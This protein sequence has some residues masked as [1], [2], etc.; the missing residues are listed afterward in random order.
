MD[1]IGIVSGSFDPITNGHVHLIS[2]ALDTL[3][4]DGTLYIVIAYNVAKKGYFSLGRRVEQITKV[5]KD[6]LPD[7]QFNQ[8]KVVTVANQYTATY[9]KKIGATV[10]YRGIRNAAD[11]AYETDIQQ[12]NHKINPDL[13]TVFFV[14]LPE[15]GHISSSVVRG[16]VGFE[17]WESVITEYVHPFII[18]NFKDQLVRI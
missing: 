13:K 3:G 12:I 8:V 4:P 1:K 7:Q 6:V 18:N 5:L 11:L 9:A 15:Y 14:P 10:M 16:L 17:G 2:R